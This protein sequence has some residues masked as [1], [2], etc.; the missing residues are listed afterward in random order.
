MDKMQ[1]EADWTI[2]IYAGGN[3]DL[4][5]EMYQAM[6]DIEKVGSNDDVNA[7]IQL[8]RAESKL[9]KLLRPDKSLREIDSWSGVRRYYV[10]K[11]HSELVGNL[12]NV[13]M[14][15]PKQLYHFI[16]WGMQTYPAKKYILALSGHSYQCVGMITDYSK[17]APY[18]MGFPEMVKAIDMAANETDNKIDLLLLDTCSANS[19]E[20][21]Y[22]FG[23]D[24]NHAAQN[25]MTY[26]VNGP[27]RGLPYDKIIRL[28]QEN[29]KTDDPDI[30]ISEITENLPYD[31]AVFQI[32]HSSL[33]QAK[34]LLNDMSFEYLSNNKNND[35]IP[36][37]EQNKIIQAVSQHFTPL[38]IHFK[39]YSHSRSPLFM[40]AV[41]VVEQMKLITNYYRLGFVQDNYWIDIMNH[42]PPDE[43]MTK[44][45]KNNHFLPLKLGPEEVYAYISVTNPELEEIQI[46]QMLINLY[47]Y[48]KWKLI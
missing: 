20:L 44:A 40:M 30:I 1:T 14:A 23:Q 34:K 35:N 11:G 19:I 13:N 37:V 31:L 9:L 32:N 46:Q 16:K 29:S 39:R 17:K 5:P 4:E 8:G 6:L 36:A 22:E 7:V 43:N 25:V 47:Q 28:V 42:T 10:K 38:I 27:I 15:D 21:M 24:E 3:N 2:L 41:N 18:I 48:K 12:Q 45:A 26:I 33:V